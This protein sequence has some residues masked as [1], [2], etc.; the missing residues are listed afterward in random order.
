MGQSSRSPR[1]RAVLKA[2]GERLHDLIGTETLYAVG[3]RARIHETSLRKMTLGDYDP[4]LPILLRLVGALE[5]HSIEE[6]LGP[7]PTS[8]F[9]A[10]PDSDES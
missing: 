5:L 2:F 3:K 4:G 7:L 6:L 1:D 10:D 8:R 9:D